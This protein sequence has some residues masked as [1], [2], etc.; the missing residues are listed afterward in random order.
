MGNS[1]AKIVRKDLTDNGI[2]VSK[3][4]KNTFLV[5]RSTD[6]ESQHSTLVIVI[7]VT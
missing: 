6:E 4:E 3:A 1:K 7:L 5:H 2:N